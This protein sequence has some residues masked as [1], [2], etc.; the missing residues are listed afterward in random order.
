MKASLLRELEWLFRLE[1]DAITQPYAWTPRSPL[2]DEERREVD[3]LHAT[4]AAIRYRGNVAEYEEQ[5]GER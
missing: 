3:R 2:S 4:G 1:A 5:E